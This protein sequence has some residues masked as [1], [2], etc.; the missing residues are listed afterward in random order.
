MKKT[1]LFVLC[2]II[3]L[4]IVWEIEIQSVIVGFVVSLIIAQVFGGMNKEYALH[5]REIKSINF[6][7]FFIRI[8]ITW[9]KAS[10]KQIYAITMQTKFESKVIEIKLSVT[11]PKIIA[12]IVWALNFYPDL[13]VV[14]EKDSLIKVSTMEGNIEW[15]K[16]EI[17]ELENLLKKVFI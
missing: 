12:F 1:S 5:L 4:L 17:K 13:I 10:I 2:F 9:I 7:V 16:T 11:E 15:V 14:Y 8:F 3:W 6:I